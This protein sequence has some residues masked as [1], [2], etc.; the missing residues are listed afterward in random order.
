MASFTR[1]DM[2]VRDL[3]ELNPLLAQGMDVIR[4]AA[5]D[6]CDDLK[7]DDMQKHLDRLKQDM[8][9]LVVQE[10]EATNIV[11]ATEALKAKMRQMPG[12]ERLGNFRQTFATEL[13]AIKAVPTDPP[14]SHA[15]F[16]DLEKI[17][18]SVEGGC[19]VG[20]GEDSM[21]VTED[22]ESGQYK[23]PITQKDIEEPVKNVK[24][25]HTYDKNSITYYI[26]NTRHPRCP[27]LGCSNKSLLRLKDLV[28]DHFVARILKQR[29]SNK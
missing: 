5:A 15:S 11:R 2:T 17:A 26:K 28:A 9:S 1:L 14:E 10:S 19:C 24:C 20:E 18:G 8:K 7:G 22:L 12:G 6:V 27:Y 21:I 3:Q 29:L 25:N 4:S 23:D 13:A 16:K